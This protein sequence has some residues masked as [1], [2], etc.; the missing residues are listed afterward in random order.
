MSDDV[1]AAE[2]RR[3]VAEIQ[4]LI[5]AEDVFHPQQEDQNW[6]ELRNLVKALNQIIEANNK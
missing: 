3:L 5:P 6:I 4:R 1:D 2:L